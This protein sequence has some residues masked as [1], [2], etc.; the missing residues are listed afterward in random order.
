MILSSGYNE[1]EAV[2]RLTSAGLTGFLQKPY[3]LDD[4]RRVISKAL[5]GQD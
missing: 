4:L 1:Q 5:N 3:S 2:Q